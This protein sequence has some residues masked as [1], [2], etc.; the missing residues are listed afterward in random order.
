MLEACVDISKQE[1]TII[2]DDMLTSADLVVTVCGHAD[3]MCPALPPDTRKLHWPLSDP[4]KA[5][6]TEAQI[7]QQFRNT[8]DEVRERVNNLLTQQ[9][10]AK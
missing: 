6:G 4:A 3:E 9:G 7:M 8:R 10:V 1:S 2:T 5:R